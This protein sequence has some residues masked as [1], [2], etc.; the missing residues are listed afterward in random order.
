MAQIV[1][2]LILISFCYIWNQS[3]KNPELTDREKKN[4][5]MQCTLTSIIIFIVTVLSFFY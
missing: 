2:V 1:L 5:T 3:I 4:I